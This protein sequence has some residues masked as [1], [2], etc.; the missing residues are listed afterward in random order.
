[1]QRLDRLRLTRS[2]TVEFPQRRCR[3]GTVSF[4]LASQLSCQPQGTIAA[5]AMAEAPFPAATLDGDS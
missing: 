1:M 5:I 4:N 2:T 3:P